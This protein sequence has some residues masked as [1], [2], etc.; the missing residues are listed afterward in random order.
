MRRASHYRH[1]LVISL[2]LL[3]HERSWPLEAASAGGCQGGHISVP[4]AARVR[5]GGMMSHWTVLQL[6]FGLTRE[7]FAQVVGHV[8]KVSGDV[9]VISLV[10]L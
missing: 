10:I 8:V 9:A 2:R 5:A 7:R 6:L 1:I 3:H 4:V